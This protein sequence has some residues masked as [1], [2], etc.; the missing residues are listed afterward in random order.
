MRPRRLLFCLLFSAAFLYAQSGRLHPFP[1]SWFGA[2][3]NITNFSGWN[4]PIATDSP[5]VQVSKEGHYVVDGR[6]IRFL[7]VNVGAATAFPDAVRAEAQTA[8]CDAD[9]LEEPALTQPLDA[10]A[11]AR[12]M[13]GASFAATSMRRMSSVR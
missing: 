13:R 10:A 1:F 5:W 9:S 6:R 11:P 3:A 2:D 12:G 8:R 4:Q 7:G